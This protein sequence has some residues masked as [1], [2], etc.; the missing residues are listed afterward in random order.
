MV[1]ALWK[2]N[3]VLFPH[4]RKHSTF[5]LIRE[6][7]IQPHVEDHRNPCQRRQGGNELAILQLRKHR[8][9]KPRM[10]SKIHQAN[11]LAET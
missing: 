3:S 9:G 4:Q 8:G 11:L 10:L 1:G 5:P 2:P 7:V 6:K